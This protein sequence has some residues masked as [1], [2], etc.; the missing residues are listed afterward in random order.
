M[1]D[2]LVDRL[3]YAVSRSRE[4]ESGHFANGRSPGKNA[5]TVIHQELSPKRSQY[6]IGSIQF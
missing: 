3:R 6:R 1:I 4:H 5:Q 2:H